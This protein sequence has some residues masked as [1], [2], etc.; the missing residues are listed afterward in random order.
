MNAKRI[1]YAY[2]IG[3]L[4]G[5]EDGKKKVG[6]DTIYTEEPITPDMVK[7]LAEK[8]KSDVIVN[9]V[10]KLK[11]ALTDEIKENSFYEK[12]IEIEVESE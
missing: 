6:Q 9:Y 10:G 12:F 8:N 1:L 11:L 4:L 2:N 7:L 3:I 5:E